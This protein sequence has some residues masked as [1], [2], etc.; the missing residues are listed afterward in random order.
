MFHLSHLRTPFP[1]FLFLCPSSIPL[2]INTCYLFPTSLLS[3]PTYPILYP[4]SQS[5]YPTYLLRS[6]YQICVLRLPDLISFLPVPLWHTSAPFS[7]LYICVPD[8]CPLSWLI[9]PTIYL[10]TSFV[11][12]SHPYTVQYVHMP[13]SQPHDIIPPIICLC[14]SF[15]TLSHQY[16]PVF[17]LLPP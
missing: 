14:L 2:T 8:P 11:I 5:P 10:C 6:L 12:L 7:H 1:T 4:I 15:V 3:N 9:P 16:M 17:Q 13:V